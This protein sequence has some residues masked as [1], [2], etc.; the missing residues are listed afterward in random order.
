MRIEIVGIG[1]KVT[2]DHGRWEYL[3]LSLQTEML[4]RRS[5]RAAGR[6]NLPDTIDYLPGLGHGDCNSGAEVRLTPAASSGTRTDV[7]TISL[8]D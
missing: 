5:R 2:F 6:E 8:Q 7:I 1:S 4:A 3:P